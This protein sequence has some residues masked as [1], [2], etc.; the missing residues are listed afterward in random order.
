MFAQTPAHLDLRT[1]M[2][3]LTSLGAIGRYTLPLIKNPLW[4]FFH[5]KRWAYLWVD[6]E[7]WLLGMAIVD[8]GYLAKSYVYFLERDNPVP[9]FYQETLSPAKG[10]IRNLANQTFLAQTSAQN[11]TNRIS[12]DADGSLCFQ[13]EGA[14]FSLSAQTGPPQDIP[15]VAA[16]NLPQGGANLTCKRMAHTG[17]IQIRYKDRFWKSDSARVCSDLTDGFLPRNTQWYWASLSGKAQSGEDI[18]LNLVE[19]FNGACECLL[20][21]EHAPIALGEGRFIG[22]KPD[23]HWQIATACGRVQLL[24]QPWSALWDQTNLGLVKSDFRQLYGTF[25]GQI[26]TDANTLFLEQVRGVAEYQSVLW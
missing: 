16:N 7:N 17:K 10:A 13:A 23:Q 21:L 5:H 9:I 25:S 2:L 1:A 8:L 15:L 24:F 11:L 19:G 22:K 4:R 18:S 20:W 6:G 3:P 14:G 12:F 26:K